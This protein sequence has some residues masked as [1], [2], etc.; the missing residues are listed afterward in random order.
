ADPWTEVDGERSNAKTRHPVLTDRAVRDALNLLVDRDSIQKHIFGRLGIAT[1][2]YLN[3]PARFQSPNRA[4]EFNPAK[5]NALLDAGGWKRGSDGVRA[6]DGRKMKLVFQTSINAP[7]QKAQQVIKQACQKAGIELE[8][9]SIASSVFFSSDEGN[10]DTSTKFYCDLQ[11]YN[12]GMGGRP[13]PN[14]LMSSF[15]SWEIS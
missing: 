13:D 2:N 6:K 9:K 11:M 3:M 8:L 12:V 5:A 15:C 14:F 1:R 7:R 4:Y 10:V